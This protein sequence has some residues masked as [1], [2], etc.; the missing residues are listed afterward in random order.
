MK[1]GKTTRRRILAAAK[2]ILFFAL[3][4][5]VVTCS[6]LLFFQYAELEEAAVRRSAPITFVNIIFLSL[7][8]TVVYEVYRRIAVDR[9]VKRILK[10]IDDI[11]KGDFSVR[12][13]KLREHGDVN[14]F[15]AIIDGFNKMA[16]E[17]SSVETLRSDFIANVSHELKTPLAAIQ[18]YGVMLREPGLDEEKRIEYAKAITDA[19]RRLANLITNILKLNRLENQQIFPETREYNLAGQ[20]C[21]CLLG[22]ED[23]WE[24][25]ELEVE[26]DIDEDIIINADEE[27]LSLVWNNL[28]SNAVKFNRERGKI[29]VRLRRD[30]EYA[31]AEVADT[32]CG[33]SPD[34]GAHI[35]EK[36][37]QGDTSHAAQGN[38]LGLALVKRVI[39]IVGGEITVNSAPNAG[40]TFSVRLKL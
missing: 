31:V 20:L 1:I 6:F 30:G 25:K 11:M 15:D 28:F 10:G 23:E 18:N 26:T 14:E 8:F 37:Y 7:I 16:E 2:F 9:P 33:I 35:F 38:G 4:A 3:S 29:T 27:L 24:K 22:F 39:D 12:I 21:E 36:F 40:S 5:G 19:S 34:V 17:L 32:G 13:K